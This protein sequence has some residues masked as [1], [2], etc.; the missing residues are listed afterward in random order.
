VS[1]ASPW[2]LLLLLAI[3]LWAW[4]ARRHRAG[5]EHP[6][7]D[8]VEIVHRAPRR[9]I[10]RLPYVLRGA[11]LAALALAVSRPRTGTT[12]VELESEGIAIVLAVDISSSMLALDMTPRDR[13]E[14][15]KETVSQFVRARAHDRLGLVAFAGEALT[16]VPLTVDHDVVRQA[17]ENLQVGQLE[18]GTAIGTAIAT[19][20]NRLRRAPGESK[21][22]V[23]LTDGENNRGEIDPLTAAQASAAYGVRIYT[24]G[25]GS[26]GVAPVPVA[27]GPF[28][29]EYANMPVRI[30]EA[31]LRR[32]AEATGGQ[33]FRAT[34]AQALSEIYA[35]IDALERTPVSVRQ[36][37]EY[38]DHGRL[39]LMLAAGL[40]LFEWL[41]RARRHALVA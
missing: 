16:Q 9:W 34:N 3:P 5:L 14:A 31:L 22:V 15:A 28:G 38:S 30:D 37:V 17:V 10:G 24:I 21:V 40:L 18:D 29:Y 6:R 20:A 35:R 25:V 32:V 12:V 27:R 19:A 2:A 13:L 26:D 33:Y 7:V 39:G 8:L 1:L 11:A 23:L 41:A 4:W 36:T